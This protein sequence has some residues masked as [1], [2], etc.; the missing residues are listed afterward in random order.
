VFTDKLLISKG[1]SGQ[2]KAV[3]R[4]LATQSYDLEEIFMAEEPN[5]LW[6]KVPLKTDQKL[7]SFALEVLPWQTF[8]PLTAGATISTEQKM[9]SGL[10]Q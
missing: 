9:L 2:V 3:S 8:L 6:S 5:S 4:D 7:L 1:S 10:F